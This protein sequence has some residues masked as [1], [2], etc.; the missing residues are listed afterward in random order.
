MMGVDCRCGEGEMNTM[1]IE[2]DE[3]ELNYEEQS[4]DFANG[5]Y[6]RGG[7]PCCECAG[8]NNPICDGELQSVIDDA[9][10]DWHMAQG[11]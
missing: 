6:C 5:R 8:T 7:Y 11:D 9:T 1:L 3:P 10:H 4:D 2:C